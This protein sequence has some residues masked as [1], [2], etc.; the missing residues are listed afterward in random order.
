MAIVDS[1]RAVVVGSDG[2]VT[3]LTG[4]PA[5]P[6]VKSS[7]KLASAAGAVTISKDGKFAIAAESGGLVVVKGVD[8]ATL[9]QVGS[10]YSPTFSTPAGTCKLSSAQTLGV[11]AD[12]KFVVTIQDCHLAKTSANVGTGVL[13]TIPFSAGTLGA[14]IGRLNFVV[15]PGNDQLLTH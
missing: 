8:T 3:L 11:M 7:L 12:G 9:A 6:I 2:S 4:L 10:V 5:C 15:T 14:P 1:S 13:L